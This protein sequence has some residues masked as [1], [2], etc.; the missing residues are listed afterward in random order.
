M[1][2]GMLSE[3]ESSSLQVGMLTAI[4]EELETLLHLGEGRASGMDSGLET[5]IEIELHQTKEAL[6]KVDKEL[7][8]KNEELKARAELIIDLTGKVGPSGRGASVDPEA[9]LNNRK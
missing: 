9:K 7:A 1:M 5:R 8:E 2:I 3:D 6:E 4:V